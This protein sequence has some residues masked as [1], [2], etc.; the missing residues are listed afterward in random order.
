MGLYSL[1]IGRKISSQYIQ[2]AQVVTPFTCSDISWSLTISC[3]ISSSGSRPRNWSCL[4]SISC[5]F[6]LLIS[7]FLF[8]MEGTIPPNCT[9]VLQSILQSG[10]PQNID[11]KYNWFTPDIEEDTREIPSHEPSIAPQNN[12]KTLILPHSKPHVQEIP[13]IKGD[14]VSKVIKNPA[15][16]GVQNT[17]YLKKVCFAQQSSSLPSRVPSREEY[18]V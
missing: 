8:M 16:D 2:T 13:A 3:R 11:M 4:T 18:K 12:N 5:G 9:D 6:L 1:C 7:T 14:P 17:S 10:T 15:S